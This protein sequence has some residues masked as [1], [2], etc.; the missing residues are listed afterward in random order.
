MTINL[1]FVFQALTPKDTA[2]SLG[3]TTICLV[4]VFQALTPKDTASSLGMTTINSLVTPLQAFF[5]EALIT[6]VLV[7][8]VEA[9]CDDRRT[10]VKGSAPLAIGLSIVTCHLAAVSLFVTTIHTRS[11]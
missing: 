7:L 11:F 10:D 2:S 5:M 8:T 1:V 9:V 4:F 6:F 3:M